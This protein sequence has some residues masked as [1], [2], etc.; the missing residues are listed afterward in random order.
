MSEHRI[1]GQAA[2]FRSWL[3]E[4]RLPQGIGN[5]LAGE[6]A[7]V[8]KAFA[9]MNEAERTLY[10]RSER[11][12]LERLWGPEEAQRKIEILGAGA[13]VAGNGC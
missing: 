11:A 2:Q 6:V 10:Q 9:A 3:E 4:A 5:F 12:H 1:V 13:A 8:S 7:A